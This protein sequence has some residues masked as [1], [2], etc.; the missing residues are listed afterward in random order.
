[1]IVRRFI[2]ILLFGLAIS[3]HG[4]D[5]ESSSNSQ[6]KVTGVCS[7]Q[8]IPF[9]QTIFLQNGYHLY[10][11]GDTGTGDSN[12]VF[13]AEILEKYHLQYPL[14]AIIHSG[15]IFYPSG[16]DR[17]SEANVDDK[18]HGIYD[19]L[20]VDNIPWY[21]V[22]GNHDHEGSIAALQDFAARSPLLNYPGR[23]F[24]HRLHKNELSWPLNLIATDTT[25]FTHNAN[26]LEQL[27]WLEQ[28]LAQHRQHINIVFGHHPVFSNGSHGDTLPL[29]AS[30]L[31]LLTFYQVPLYLSGHEHSLEILQ[32]KA[33]PTYLISGAGGQK[34]RAIACAK[35]SLYAAQEYGGIA[36]FITSTNIWLI[37]VTHTSLVVMFQLPLQ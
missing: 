13:S 4:C 14:D 30:F 3:I 37:P 12:Q 5:G 16:I 23:Y 22:A 36:M 21:L 10:L 2:L 8:A 27:A 28:Q 33:G 24:L 17:A 29:K 1:M 19:N 20:A 11:I 35:N 31:D 26:Q 25:P 32:N 6:D 7:N 15:D 34:L 18:F 9:D